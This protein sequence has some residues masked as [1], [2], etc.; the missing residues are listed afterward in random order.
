MRDD[1]LSNNLIIYIKKD[2]TSQFSS[3]AIMD[4]FE[5]LKCRRVQYS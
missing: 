1:F 4:E 3:D 5:S 2:I